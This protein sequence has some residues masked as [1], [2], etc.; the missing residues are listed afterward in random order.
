[1]YSPHELEKKKLELTV[2]SSDNDS[3]YRELGVEI[4]SSR[5]FNLA[6]NEH[7][8]G[9]SYNKCFATVMNEHYTDA[10]CI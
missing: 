5:R 9:A 1:M 8:A 10:S 3:I 7:S 6:M 4:L 2:S